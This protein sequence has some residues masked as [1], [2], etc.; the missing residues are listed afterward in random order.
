[1]SEQEE[2]AQYL[3]AEYG[4]KKLPHAANQLR[5]GQHSPYATLDTGTWDGQITLVGVRFHDGEYEL[6]DYENN[7]RRYKTFD[8]MKDGLAAFLESV[9]EEH[10]ER[11]VREAISR[12]RR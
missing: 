12:P 3:K 2:I 9:R 8:Q 11:A 4:D 1:M 6:R 10:L 7:F 5:I